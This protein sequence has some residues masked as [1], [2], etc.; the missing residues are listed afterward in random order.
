MTLQGLVLSLFTDHY[1]LSP[2]TPKDVSVRRKKTK[3]Q[4]RPTGVESESKLS[5]ICFR[6]S[7]L[8]V[9][10]LWIIL[11]VKSPWII[12][13]KTNYK[14]QYLP[15]LAEHLLLTEIIII[16]DAPIHFSV[17]GSTAD[18]LPFS[19]RRVF[20]AID[21]GS[22]FTITTNALPLASQKERFR[23]HQRII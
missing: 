2:S 11:T 4:S 14:L 23:K 21:S 17:A 5:L 13:H 22:S 7:L 18:G 1:D 8:T 19:R 3:R 15:N 16:E 10:S 20:D 12:N 9:T 6:Q